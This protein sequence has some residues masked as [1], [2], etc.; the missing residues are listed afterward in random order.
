[1]LAEADQWHR[2][3]DSVDEVLA[4]ERWARD[5]ARAQLATVGTAAWQG[6]D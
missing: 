5:R 3:P 1:V 4:A 2:E 6:R